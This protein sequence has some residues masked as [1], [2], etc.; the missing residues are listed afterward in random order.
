MIGELN[1]SDIFLSL[2]N[3]I[4][5]LSFIII[6]TA[7]VMLNYNKLQ[8]NLLQRTEKDFLRVQ[9]LFYQI[10]K[11]QASNLQM[12]L[13]SVIN[14]KELISKFENGDRDGLAKDLVPFFKDRLKPVYGIKQFQFHIP[15][16]T[17]YLRVH[18]PSKFGDD[19]S[20]FRGTVVY[21]NETQKPAVG[22]EVG[23]GGPGL[24]VVLP[25]YGSKQQHLGS[26]EFGGGLTSILKQ[27]ANLYSVEYA[28]GI[29]DKIFKK[30]KR[31]QGKPTDV[32][33][34]DV[35]YYE[36]SSD[37]ANLH[38][39]DMPRITI[40]RVI[41][42]GNLATYSFPI[43]DFLENIVGYVTVF[44]DLSEEKNHIQVELLKF[45]AWIFGLMGVASLLM[46]IILGR[47]ISPLNEFIH[48]LDG[49]TDGDTG[50]DLTQRLSTKQK[51]EIGKASS[52]I[53]KFIELTMV[54]IQEIKGKS[55]SSID[56]GGTVHELSK[57]IH[58]KSSH[59]RNLLGKVDILSSKVRSQAT[60][61]QSSTED[62]LKAILHEASLIANML[63]NLTLVK[64]DMRVISQDEIK[65]ATEISQ[66]SNE[67]TKVKEITELIDS[68]S[69][70]TNL[71]AL[72][73]SIEAAR[74]G[75]HGKGFS[76]VASEIHTLSAKTQE[77]LG[78]IDSK[79]EFLSD[80][81][82]DLSQRMVKNSKTVERLSD[83]VEMVF[84]EA[85]QLGRTSDNTIMASENSKSNTEN[86]L[87]IID[88]LNNDMMD[89]LRITDGNDKLSAQLQDVAQNLNSSMNELKD[90]MGLFKTEIEEK[91]KSR[92]EV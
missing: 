68:I 13:E 21:T 16:A 12:A 75:V 30:A 79:M 7:I 49:L 11:T 14:S 65:I 61:A 47:I 40:D 43:Y 53:N 2:S 82:T 15:K 71:L 44:E 4:S 56:L 5:I 25:V 88:E 8:T 23:R 73:A 24:R 77:A 60:A 41:L 51:D 48:V 36:Y 37:Q 33:K 3:F 87:H 46:V 22:V 66:L 55:L 58:N 6:G 1:L 26:V 20:S 10:S 67:V 69:D 27:I 17:S 38:V 74:A 63:K 39:N 35:I 70:Q 29:E 91:K 85:Y 31:F 78:S 89:V 28:I 18:K 9:E 32:R 83:D 80:I 62:T 92:E 45:T 52:S 86:I 90:K 57:T 19:L 42:D 64:E 34:G 84:K 72:N 76:V 81:V 59:Q 54:L 50:G